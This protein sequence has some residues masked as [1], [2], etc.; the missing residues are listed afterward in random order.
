MSVNP[1]PQ[2]VD[3]VFGNRRYYIDLLFIF[4]SFPA[5]SQI[6]KM[7]IEPFLSLIAGNFNKKQI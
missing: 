2:T 7:K 1:K 5:I 6:V 3:S 4:R